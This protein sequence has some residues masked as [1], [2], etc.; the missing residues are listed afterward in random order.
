MIKSV[1]SAI[2]K[3]S[4][5]RQQLMIKS[6]MIT[7]KCNYSINLFSILRQQSENNKFS[8]LQFVENKRK[9]REEEWKKQQNKL[10]QEQLIA[11]KEEVEN[12]NNKTS[13][14]STKTTTETIIKKEKSTGMTHREFQLHI[15]KLLKRAI[16]E[17]DAENLTVEHEVLG[18]IIP[19]E[20]QHIRD[21]FRYSLDTSSIQFFSKMNF[22]SDT[23]R[24]D[25][26]I[27]DKL[28]GNVY[29]YD[30][31]H[32]Q[33]GNKVNVFEIVKLYRDIKGMEG[34]GGGLIISG[35]STLD[36]D[37]QYLCS[38]EK[39][40]LIKYIKRK[41]DDEFISEFLELFKKRIERDRMLKK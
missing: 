4:F 10:F 32:Y 27:K 3:L 39:F 5:S 26:V 12:I 20:R 28:T 35:S 36:K 16:K 7:R 19:E 8:M 6:S 14:T 31:K 17:Y 25:F 41:G 29:V 40:D 21:R 24:P 1:G 38:K 15:L 2:S 30:A 13:K 23:I 22:K 33:K 34:I 37:A 11:Y 18:V 9:E